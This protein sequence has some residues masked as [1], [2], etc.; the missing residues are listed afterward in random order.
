MVADDNWDRLRK[1]CRLF[2]LRFGLQW[3]YSESRSLQQL[4]L[5]FQD[6]SGTSGTE[7]YREGGR[8]GKVGRKVSEDWT[9]R[10]ACE[11]STGMF[12]RMKSISW[13]LALEPIT[14]LL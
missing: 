12:A 6:G 9:L 5:R 2:E 8:V 7:E 14:G 3:R 4:E 11:F 1:L 10:R 13:S